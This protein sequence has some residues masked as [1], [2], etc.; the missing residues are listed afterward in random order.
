MGERRAVELEILGKRPHVAA[1]EDR[2]EPHAEV[3]LPAGRHAQGELKV[4][5]DVADDGEDG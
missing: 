2:L 5:V 1:Q 4:A 3:P